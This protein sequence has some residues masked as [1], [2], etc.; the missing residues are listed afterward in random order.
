MEYVKSNKSGFNKLLYDNCIYVKQKVLKNGAVCWEPNSFILKTT[1][2]PE[3]ILVTI[4][5]EKPRKSLK[6]ETQ[7]FYSGGFCLGGFCLGGL[8][9]GFLSVGYLL[10]GFCPGIFVL[11][12]S[13]WMSNCHLINFLDLLITFFGFL[14]FPHIDFVLDIR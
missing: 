10:G 11:E 4:A 12:P 5:L 14:G 3:V 2:L 8:S 13:N 9:W 6:N 7:K 1:N